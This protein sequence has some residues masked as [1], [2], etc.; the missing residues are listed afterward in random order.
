MLIIVTASVTTDVGA[1][2]RPIAAI[3]SLGPNRLAHS[4]SDVPSLMDVPSFS[5]KDNQ[6]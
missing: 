2:F 3:C 5:E 1:Q 6:A 4:S